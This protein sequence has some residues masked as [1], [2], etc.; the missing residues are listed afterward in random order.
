MLHGENKEL[1]FEIERLKWPVSAVGLKLVGVG[2][3]Y[4][5]DVDLDVDVVIVVVWELMEL[6]GRRC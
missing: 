2:M 4:V 6:T 3:G 5:V 1:G